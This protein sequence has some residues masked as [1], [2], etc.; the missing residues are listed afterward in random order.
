MKYIVYQTIN[1]INNKI[2]VGV[3]GTTNPDEFDGYIGNGVSIYRPA[4]YMNPKTHFQSAV[5]KYGIKAF[6]RTTLK[7]FDNEE[8]AY[9]MEEEIVNE[10]FL[11]RPDV[12]N[13]AK[14]G[15]LEVL[16]SIPKKKVYM[17]DLDG[18]FEM[19]FDGVNEAGRFLNPNASGAGHL[20]R[21][22]KEG[23]QYLGH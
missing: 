12:Y 14:G 11:K 23:H 18:N 1:K 10:E 13:L 19:E 17:Y 9:K 7:V 20:P 15:R 16:N 5:K 3:H 22:I 4:T 8:D 6:I 21:A 2:Y